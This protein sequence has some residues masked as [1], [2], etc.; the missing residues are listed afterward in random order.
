MPSEATI[1]AP[2]KVEGRS[3]RPGDRLFL[4]DGSSFVFRAYFQSMNQDAKYNYRS[5]GLPTGALRL[6]STKLYQFLLEGAVGLTPTHMAIVFDK[7]EQTF[8]KEIYADYKATRKDPPDDLVPQFPLMREAVQAFGLLPVEQAGFEADDV[9]ATYAT[10][11]E[12][13]GADTLIISADKDLMQLVSDHVLFYDFESGAR[14]RPGYRPERKIDRDGVIEYFGMPPDKVV[15]IQALVGDPS[16]NVPGV[17]GIGLKTAA[18]LISEYGSLEALLDRVNE[19]KQPKRRETLIANADNARMSKLLVSLDRAVAVDTPL[20][21]SVLPP[22][23]ARRLLSFLK[24]MELNTLVKRV[25]EAAGIDPE[26]VESDPKLRA[27]GRG[28]AAHPGQVG[29]LVGGYTKGSAVTAPAGDAAAAAEDG[30]A[31]TPAASPWSGG[32]LFGRAEPPAPPTDIPL[33]VFD[34]EPG[35]EAIAATVAT[36]PFDPSSYQTI[37]GLSGLEALV[38]EAWRTGTIGLAVTTAVADPMRADIVGLGIATAAGRSAYIPLGHRDGTDDLLASGLAAGQVD[39]RRALELLRPVLEDPAII[40]VGHDFKATTLLLLRYGIALA[41]IDD[42]M[43]M[44]YALEAGRR[45]VS[46]LGLSERWLNHHPADVKSLLGSGRNAITFDR[47]ALGPATA[48]TAEA[49]DIVLRLATV[50]K[51]RLITNRVTTVYETLE[52]PMVRVLADMERHGIMVDRQ[53]LSRL[54]GDF[55]QTMGGLEDEIAQ[56]AGEPFNIGSPKQLGDILFGKMGLPGGRKT[57]TGAWS[58][59][60]DILEELA[61]E[62]ALPAKILEWRQ[63]S[64]LK[65]TYTDALPGFIHPETGRVH[66]SYALAATPTARLSSSEPNLQ[67]IPV[68][69]ELGRKI[70]TA[71]VAEDGNKLISADYSQIELRVLAHIAEIPQLRAAFADG[72]DIHAITASEMF[73]V[74]VAGMPAD[75]R[76]R[77]KAINFGIIYGISAF[78]LANQL[79]I[80]RAEAKDYIDR[81]FQKFPGI[82]DYMESTKAF[83]RANGYVE[84]IFRRKCHYPLILSRNPAERAFNERA[85]VNATIQG[86][87]ADIIRRAMIRMPAALDHAGLKVRMLLQVHDELVFEAPDS[88]VDDALPLI[89]RVMEA[90]PEPVVKLRV[91]IQ[92]DAR[93]GSNWEAAH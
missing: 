92:V 53:I 13:A 29:T 86:S 19:I 38:D 80:P 12:K 25:S 49:A 8:R 51:P 41:P 22:F 9:I 78:G 16:D 73:G 74:P 18:Q 28:T 66:T 21:A 32:D 47:V 23:D 45:D 4:V 7:A 67:N 76:R 5:D 81:Y 93:A 54:S 11:A 61:A 6:F 75:V 82:R 33:T 84:T 44:A 52:R 14:G 71:F 35:A 79:S 48:Y 90:S 31:L 30:P 42:V 1:A 68:R 3:P 15:D 91:P 27:K 59:D 70:R 36:I 57:K 56:L 50:L 85:A 60:A 17:P 39:T 20:A 89:R 65:S 55:A 34:A 72:L 63:V 77:A 58:T 2:E 83:C 87:A 46:L 10:E 62:H 64:K 40:K 26:T 88:Q 69:T 37:T 24:A 43:L